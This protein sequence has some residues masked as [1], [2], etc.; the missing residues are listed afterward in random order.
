MRLDPRSLALFRIF[1]GGVLVFDLALAMKNCRAFYLDDGILPRRLLLDL[2]GDSESSWSVYL[3]SSYPLV[4]WFFLIVSMFAALALVAGFR[5]RLASLV[6]WVLLCSLQVRNP[7]V[8]HGG[9][10]AIRVF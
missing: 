7:L 10:S 9:D 6:S 3:A 4:I 5:T 8:L 2:L 1:L